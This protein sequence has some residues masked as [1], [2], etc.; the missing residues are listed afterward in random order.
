MIADISYEC[1][2]HYARCHDDRSS[3]SS[4]AG[5]GEK[6]LLWQL[7]IGSNAPFCL[8]REAT[9][10]VGGPGAAGGASEYSRP[11]YTQQCTSCYTRNSILIYS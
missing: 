4:W 9:A 2:M 3:R 8:L 11:E 1:W 10:A 6:L 5:A 7:A